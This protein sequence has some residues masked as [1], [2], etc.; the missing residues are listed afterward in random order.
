M[1]L[2]QDTA[3]KCPCWRLCSRA[4]PWRSKDSARGHHAYRAEDVA[5][6]LETKRTPK[7]LGSLNSLGRARARR[8][9]RVS[10]AAALHLWPPCAPNTMPRRQGVFRRRPDVLRQARARPTASAVVGDSCVFARLA[11][12]I[13]QAAERS[14]RHGPAEDAVAPF[15]CGFRRKTAPACWLRSRVPANRTDFHDPPVRQRRPA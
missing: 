8:G 4:S 11:R 2:R 3:Q 9:R 6:A 14:R 12:G 7:L 10:D 15:T 13:P 1:D 5:F